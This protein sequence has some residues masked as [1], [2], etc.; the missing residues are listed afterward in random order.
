MN[1]KIFLKKKFGENYK[2]F[3]LKNILILTF[4][5]FYFK[6]R[7]LK[8]NIQSKFA[9]VKINLNKKIEHQTFNN[10]INI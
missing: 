4:G 1:Y 3:Y 10:P 7:D 2:K 5:N 6:A 9:F 8:K